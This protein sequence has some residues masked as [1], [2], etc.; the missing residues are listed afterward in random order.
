MCLC[1]VEDAVVRVLARVCVCEKC[2]R[3]PTSQRASLKLFEAQRQNAPKS[4]Q[5]PLKTTRAS[6]SFVGARW[7][8]LV[9]VGAR[10]LGYSF[11]FGTGSRFMI[12][13]RHVPPGVCVCDL[14]ISSLVNFI[15][16]L[17]K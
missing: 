14:V 11:H 2:A 4:S 9:L 7:C 17:L 1:V 3:A 16:L 10:A 8:S 6:M 13:A 12:V 5:N 15:L